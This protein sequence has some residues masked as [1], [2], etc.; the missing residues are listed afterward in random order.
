MAY[1]VAQNNKNMPCEPGMDDPDIV[2]LRLQELQ[3]SRNRVALEIAEKRLQIFELEGGANA[4]NPDRVRSSTETLCREL[5]KHL[6]EFKQGN[7]SFAE[8]K[9]LY[10]F[11][12][13]SKARALVE[14]ML[15]Y[16]PD[17][18]PRLMMVSRIGNLRSFKSDDVTMIEHPLSEAVTTTHLG[19]VLKKLRDLTSYLPPLK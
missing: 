16:V 5:E 19:T 15:Q 10:D 18:D 7:L 1:V 12:Y 17:N 6:D 3:Q 13:R 4:E 8:I 2:E 11:H 14:A 9:K